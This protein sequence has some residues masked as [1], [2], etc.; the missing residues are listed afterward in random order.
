MSQRLVLIP[1]LQTLVKGVKVEHLFA[2]F[3]SVV[4]EY[5]IKVPLKAKPIF[6]RLHYE[7]H[8]PLGSKCRQSIVL[9]VRR[10]DLCVHQKVY[11]IIVNASDL[12]L[13]Y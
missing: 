4:A 10:Q 12:V 3:K 5:T 7:Y 1:P 2:H 6:P 13:L 8:I 11:L 9:Q